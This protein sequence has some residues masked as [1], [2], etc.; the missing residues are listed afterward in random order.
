M[1]LVEHLREL[2]RRVLVSVVALLVGMVV[3]IVFATDIYD[4][5][6]A[7]IMA[8]FQQEP[9]SRMDH[10][11]AYITSPLRSWV[12]AGHVQGA[13]NV[14]NSPLEGMYSYFQIG[15]VGGA[16]LASPIIASQLWMFVAPG[17]YKSERR[18]VL[19]LTIASTGLFLLG[20]AFCY[21][22][23]FPVLFPVLLT[24]L[25]A[26]A[27]ISV[28][29]YLEAVVRMMIGFGICFQLPVVVWFLAR[30]G[31]IDHRDMIT[32]FRYAIVG[33]FVAAAIV[34]PTA[35]VLTQTLL[36]VPMCGLYGIGIIVA[37]FATTKK[38]EATWAT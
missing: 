13:L 16:V 19:P 33:I 25:E 8:V 23:V 27:V 29:G 10:F 1:P 15:L 21:A 7:P 18:L 2:R 6:R 32:M 11:Y 36:A 14:A 28:R 17:L 26:S 37:F 9:T 20:A 31:L 38:R 4:F 34:T 30:I 3:G 5:L 12:P 24:A 22:V 35:D